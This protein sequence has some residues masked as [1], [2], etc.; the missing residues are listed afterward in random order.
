MID[1]FCVR[2]Q[3]FYILYYFSDNKEYKL[4]VLSLMQN[5]YFLKYVSL[6]PNIIFFIFFGF[7]TKNVSFMILKP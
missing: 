2:E 3:N 5:L 1:T 6:T 4:W 7:Q